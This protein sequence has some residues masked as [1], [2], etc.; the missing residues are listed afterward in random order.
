MALVKAAFRLD[1]FPGTNLAR[2]RPSRQRPSRL[3]ARLHLPDLRHVRNTTHLDD[4]K[5]VGGVRA[6]ASAAGLLPDQ[7]LIEVRDTSPDCKEG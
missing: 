5:L 3:P 4:D 6:A 2:R 7:P 1:L